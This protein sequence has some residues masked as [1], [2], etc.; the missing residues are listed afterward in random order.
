ML[1]LGKIDSEKNLLNLTFNSG[2]I[3]NIIAIDIN[4]AETF[5][6]PQ[7]MLVSEIRNSAG[8]LSTILENFRKKII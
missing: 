7:E 6:K 8:E 1:A 5:F 4:E 2:N 3:L